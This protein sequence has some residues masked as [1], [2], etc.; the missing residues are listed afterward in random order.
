MLYVEFF[1]F[2]FLPVLTEEET[3]VGGVRP[4]PIVALLPT[5]RKVAVEWWKG[6]GRRNQIKSKLKI[7][8]TS[9]MRPQGGWWRWKEGGWS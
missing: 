8:K 7:L 9:Y 4:P 6:R 1:L 2:S 3:P 5:W